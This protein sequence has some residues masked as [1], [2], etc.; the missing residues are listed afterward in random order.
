MITLVSRRETH[1]LDHSDVNLMVGWKSLIAHKNC[2]SCSSPVFQ[3]AKMSS[4]YLHQI[5]GLSV[6]CCRSCA[7]SLPIKM[8]VYEDAILVPI[9]LLMSVDSAHH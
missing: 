3:I 4:M 8:L 9:S 5:D 6:V 1:F 7:S 2:C